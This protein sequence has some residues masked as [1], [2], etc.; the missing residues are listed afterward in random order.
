MK[1]LKSGL[2]MAALWEVAQAL[3]RARTVDASEA[4]GTALS[5]HIMANPAVRIDLSGNIQDLEAVI[6]QAEPGAEVRLP[7]GVFML[8]RPLV[9]TQSIT[10]I[11]AGM[12]QTRIVCRARELVVRFDSGGP[13]HARNIPFAHEGEEPAHVVTVVSGPFEFRSCRFTGAVAGQSAI[14]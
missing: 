1:S 3:L 4:R 8:S 12:D 13:F 5:S 2:R 6:R 14:E 11:G 10:L 9:V 7:A